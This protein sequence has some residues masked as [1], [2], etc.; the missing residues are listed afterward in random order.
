[1]ALRFGTFVPQEGLD[2]VGFYGAFNAETRLCARLQNVCG[3]ARVEVGPLVQLPTG[4]HR[5]FAI[6]RKPYDDELA[7]E[8]V[9]LV[10]EDAV[11]QF[12]RELA[13]SA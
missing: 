1:M 11:K 5:M 4:I 9:K 3:V 10:V 7:R 13:K 8:M 6:E 12:C 2:A